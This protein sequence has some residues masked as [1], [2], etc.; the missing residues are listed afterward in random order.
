MKKKRHLTPR[1]PWRR[2]AIIP[3]KVI[4]IEKR[5]KIQKKYK[6]ALT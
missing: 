6:M 4:T 3:E 2:D 1:S 5:Q